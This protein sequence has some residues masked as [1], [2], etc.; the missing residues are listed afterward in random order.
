MSNR[1]IASIASLG[2]V[3]APGAMKFAEVAAART[4]AADNNNADNA[5][6]PET[7]CVKKGG[8]EVERRLG[9]DKDIAAELDAKTAVEVIETRGTSSHIA[10]TFGGKPHVGW[11]DSKRLG[12]CASTGTGTPAPTGTHPHGGGTPAGNPASGGPVMQVHLIDVGQ[13]AAT[14]FEFSCGAM[15][16]DSGG[17]T[18]GVFN[19]GDAL[20]AYLDEFFDRR[21]DLN[22]TLD[23]FVLTH[24]HLDHTLN[25]KLVAE[26]YTVKNVVTDGRTDGS[27]GEGQVFLQDWAKDHG[28]LETID[29]AAVPAGG[30]TSAVIDPIHCTDED[31][32]SKVLWGDVK[33]K[34][35]GWSSK[36]FADA[37]NKSVAVRIDFGKASVLVSGDLEEEGIGAL[38]DKHHGTDALDVDVWQV[39]HHGSDNGT[40]RAL[41]DALTPEIALLAT[42]DSSRHESWSAWKYG[43]PRKVAIDL[44]EAAVTARRPAADELVATGVEDFET[45]SIAK[46][47]YATG[48]D[49]SVVVTA[50]PDGSFAVKTER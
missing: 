10:Y 15:L 14:L 35:T 13:G 32:R 46:A 21:P 41:L 8:A 26:K 16:I 30:K 31:P 11:V 43:H 9:G 44:L 18:N 7:R 38:L 6:A 36:A 1:W 2:L 17:E 33:Q 4:P 19:S 12:D 37:N 5:D 29:S 47:I 42:G 40:T 23:L 49:G 25:A 48:W 20:K 3:A 34:P 50:K 22:R 39:G 45:E 24:P 27:G 28:K